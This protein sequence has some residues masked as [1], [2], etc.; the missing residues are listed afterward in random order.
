MHYEDDYV[1]N[2]K[3]F[4]IS[5][6]P[7][8][9]EQR[10]QI[11]INLNSISSILRDYEELCRQFN[12][13]IDD[14]EAQEKE[15]SRHRHRMN[16]EGRQKIVLN[17]ERCTISFLV[18][19]IGAFAIGGG[20]IT[21]YGGSALLY[22]G[23]TILK[24][25]NENKILKINK[26]GRSKEAIQSDIHL[27]YNKALEIETYLGENYVINLKKLL[28]TDLQ[29]IEDK[30]T[31]R[32]N[33]IQMKLD[34]LP[35]ISDIMMYTPPE[36][37]LSININIIGYLPKELQVFKDA[38]IKSLQKLN[39]F[40]DEYV[41]IKSIT[42]DEY[43]N[44][45]TEIRNIIQQVKDKIDKLKI[46]NSNLTY[47][48]TSTEPLTISYFVEHM[49]YLFKM[50]YIL[51]NIEQ[52]VESTLHQSS[53]SNASILHQIKK[54]IEFV[55]SAIFDNIENTKFREL[56]Q[57]KLI[58]ITQL[59]Q[60]ENEDAF[61]YQMRVNEKFKNDAIKLEIYEPLLML[62]ISN[63]NPDIYLQML[64][65][66][67]IQ[68]DEILQNYRQV[69]KLIS[70][71]DM[72]N[73]QHYNYK[74]L[75]LKKIDE[76]FKIEY[77]K[78]AHSASQSVEINTDNLPRTIRA[79]NEEVEKRQSKDV[80]QITNAAVQHV[81]RW[82]QMMTRTYPQ[83]ENSREEKE[84][85]ISVLQGHYPKRAEMI[86]S[87]LKSGVDFYIVSIVCHNMYLTDEL[88]NKFQLDPIIYKD[89]ILNLIEGKM[90]FSDIDKLLNAEK[91]MKDEFGLTSKEI[92]TLLIEYNFD[93]P[94][95][96]ERLDKQN[97]LLKLGVINRQLA[98]QLLVKSSGNV[99]T[100]RA[101]AI[102]E[103]L[104]STPQASAARRL[105][106]DNEA[107]RATA[108]AAVD[109]LFN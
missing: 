26:R 6:L 105:G 27:L 55:N 46:Y 51:G 101:K 58:Y 78:N 90:V 80:I 83:T 31:W 84:L 12:I 100:A 89:R 48:H 60:M 106:L 77:V 40:A 22:A 81:V 94:L 4:L 25:R 16:E 91:K 23:A 62:R 61:Q 5:E 73:L 41:K 54:V 7:V 50:V 33:N 92:D 30:L 29:F 3:T 42:T 82:L 36:E 74:K 69:I 13:A 14:E 93:L 8:R 95:I 37:I 63:N 39:Q 9:A 87:Q 99:E 85:L 19:A 47:T 20:P 15:V 75:I 107:L 67:D 11:I 49:T 88:I 21:F 17:G 104:I 56:Y 34:N 10:E 108:A 103:D 65:I 68:S 59:F 28:S 35:K 57:L 86:N 109:G 71:V 98:E 18:G 66:R 76:A 64:N 79:F 1:E 43:L 24:Y 96:R 32:I 44:F 52:D 45:I 38:R 53:N 2:Q 70:I 72:R 102:A 97:I